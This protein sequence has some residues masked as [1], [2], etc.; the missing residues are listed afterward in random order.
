MARAGR[1]IQCRR[2]LLPSSEVAPWKSAIFAAQAMLP[3]KIG[4]VP[5]GSALLR[6]AWQH[7]TN[8]AESSRKLEIYLQ[9]HTAISTTA[10][11]NCSAVH[12]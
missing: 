9:I 7:T 11:V 12:P 2:D 10:L 8:R 3:V 5:A 1:P 6:S 4:L